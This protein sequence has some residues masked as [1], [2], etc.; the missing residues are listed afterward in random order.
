MWYF[1]DLDKRKHLKDELKSWIGTRYRH[2]W[3]EKGRGADCIYLVLQVLVNTGALVSFK[4]YNY[5]LDASLH[6]DKEILLEG[7]RMLE[8]KGVCK[9]VGLKSFMDGDVLLYKDPIASTH[10]AMYCNGF[11]YHQRFRN[12][13]HRMSVHQDRKNLTYNFR[14]LVAPRHLCVCNFKEDKS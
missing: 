6:S 4:I 8:R 5:P 1:D 3:G 14:F 11:V 12:R 13:V 2:R 10:S 9:E 7:Y